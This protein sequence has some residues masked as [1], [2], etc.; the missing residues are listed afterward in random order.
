[1]LLDFAQLQL[2][3]KGNLYHTLYE[4]IKSAVECGAIKKGEKLPS[5][6]EAAASLGVSRTTVE[7]AY[8]RLCIEGIAESIPQKGYFLTGN[9]GI[10]AKKTVKNGVSEKILYDFSSRRTDP[11][12]SDTEVWKR[13]VRKVLWDSGELNSYGEA[14]GETGLREALSAY[15]Y[16]ARGVRTS[17]DNIVIGAGVGPLLN[18]LCGLLGRNVKIGMENSFGT[19]QSILSDY[20]IKNVLLQSDKSGAIINSIE[21]SDIDVLFLLPSALSKISVNALANRRNEYSRWVKE[22]SNRLIIEDDY[23]GELRYT[24]R[25]VPA[26][27][28]KE[29]ENCVYIGSFSKLLLPSVRIAYMVL[30][31][32]LAEKFKKREGSFN[33]TC[34]KIEQLALTEYIVNGALEKHLKRLRRLY[35]AKSQILINEIKVNIPEADEIKL[36]ESSL[37]LTFKIQSNITGEEIYKKAL[38]RGLRLMPSVESKEIRLCFAGIPQTEIP[39]AVKLLREVIRKG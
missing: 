11:D 8:T 39:D 30:P 33:Q 24:A 4:N 12:A 28:G 18:I 38:M 13:L 31:D 21:E 20:G 5:V 7:N 19:A 2:A 26:F 23:N 29:P 9:K 35:Y 14:Q 1:M 37:I 32:A 34:G 27:Q 25:A 16:K 22:H 15:S 6:R 17:P 36:Y 10:S 3:D